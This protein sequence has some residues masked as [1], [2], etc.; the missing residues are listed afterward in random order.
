MYLLLVLVAIY[1][2]LHGLSNDFHVFYEYCI[3]ILQDLFV[4]NGL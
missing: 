2:L 3:Y 4:T 1:T